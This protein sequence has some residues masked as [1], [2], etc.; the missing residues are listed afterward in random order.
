MLMA[1]KFFFVC[2]C[3]GGWQAKCCKTGNRKIDYLSKNCS[4][5]VPEPFVALS[6]L[7]LGVY[8]VLFKGC[9][10]KKLNVCRPLSF[11]G[12]GN[13]LEL[14]HNPHHL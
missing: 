14:K 4:Y 13:R 3:N 7:E 5:S 10:N 11:E 12:R 9:S 2:V 6:Q 1:K 8:I